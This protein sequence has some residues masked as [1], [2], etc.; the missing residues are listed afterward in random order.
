MEGFLFVEFHLFEPGDSSLVILDSSEANGIKSLFDS[1]LRFLQVSGI[2]FSLVDA[3]RG[4]VELIDLD[5]EGKV[6]LRM[7]EPEVRT[8]ECLSAGLALVHDELALELA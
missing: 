3:R 1:D 5:P 2:D 7:D 4:L 8:R 6:V